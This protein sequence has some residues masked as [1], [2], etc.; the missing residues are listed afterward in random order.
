MLT[1]PP[2]QAGKI[3]PHILI[4]AQLCGITEVY[5][6]GGVQA[7]AAMAYGTQTIPKVDKIFGPG[8]SWVTQAKALVAQDPQ[9]AV[10]DMPAGPSEVMVIAD[11][12]AKV[13]FI[14]ADLL[15]QAEHGPDSQVVCI[16]TSESLAQS[17][18][19]QI[20]IQCASLSRKKIAEQS[21][22]NSHIIVVDDIKQAIDI[23]NRY[24]PE[25][26]ILQLENAQQYVASIYNAGAVFLGYWAPETVGDY[27]TGSNHVLPTYGYARALSG[28]S[29]KDFIRFLSVQSLTPEGLKV[30]GPHAEKLAGIEGLDAHQRAVSIRLKQLEKSI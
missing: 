5:K 19:Q 30:I 1:T 10:C 25:H 13:E 7:I 9:G 23:S 28:L 20:Q 16:T 11:Q 17:C 24:A 3:D 2:N 26:L 12:T 29:L 4:T 14:T 22:A 6:V 27:V 15:S 21:L 8:N 18:L